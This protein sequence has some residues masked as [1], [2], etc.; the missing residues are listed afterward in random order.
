MHW[1]HITVGFALDVIDFLGIGLI[2]ILGDVVDVIGALYF[3]RFVGVL[4]LAGLVEIIPLF[5]IL[6]TFTALGIYAAIKE[7]R[8]R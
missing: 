3:Y 6:P 2:P 8:G 1:L 5:D 7:K 4:S